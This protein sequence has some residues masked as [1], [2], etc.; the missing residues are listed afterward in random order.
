MDLPKNGSVVIID[1]KIN[2]ALPLMNALA[3][4]GVPYFYYDG[5]GK[6]SYPEK[7]LDN[8]R[9]IFLDMHL[10]EAAGGATD[11]KS[12]VSLLV[13][14]INAIVNENNGP[15]VVMVWSKHDSQHLIELEDT[16]LNK[17]SVSCRPIAVLNMEK[18]LCFES[19]CTDKDG[20][21]LE[22]KLKND[23][24]DI[25]EKN[26]NEQLK[27]VDSFL[28]LCNWENGI[29]NSAKET[30][31]AIGTLFDRDNQQWN[32]NLKACMVRMAKAYAGRMLEMSDE[33]IIK[34]VYYSMNN[35]IGDFNG[36][37][38]EQMVRRVTEKIQL[39]KEK[40]NVIGS[41]L[42]LLKD[43]G[44]EYIL[45]YDEKKYY[46]YKES[47]LIW[48]NKDMKKLLKDK[49][50]DNDRIG[51]LLYDMY[52]SNI[53][54]VNSMLNIRKYI[55]DQKRPGNIY[56]ASEELKKEICEV[57]NIDKSSWEDIRG[58]ELEISPICDYAQN[59]RKRLR[60]LPGLE[61]PAKLLDKDSSKY[62]YLTIPIMIDGKER[63][64][65]FDFRFYI[66]ELINYFDAK[67]PLYAI[68]DGLLQNIKEELSIHSVRSG[69][70]YVE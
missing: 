32:D 6:K 57:R 8:V 58:I 45:S 44:E 17:N 33:N 7:P 10:D 61:I 34:N 43:A 4:R 9:I 20:R 64:I 2:E 42:V 63:R 13:A 62:T 24:M 15:Y 47:T 56:E 21:E 37:E 65:L 67:K 50:N 12:I 28:I 30:V 39:P 22:W 49:I 27:I 60:I 70:V 51:V 46:V 26:L 11:T 48:Q 5:K 38:A 54:S 52:L 36:V 31:K 53:C 41:V 59:K 68:G 40:N 3:K 66:S 29:K 18:S 1:D 55:I 23:G 69:I 16:L 35:I 25:I 19:V 14:G